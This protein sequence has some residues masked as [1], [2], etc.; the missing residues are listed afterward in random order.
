M[1]PLHSR[2]GATAV[3]F[4]LTMPILIAVLGGLLEYSWYL[5]SLAGVV[6]ATREGVRYGATLA[7]KDSPEVEAEAHAAVVLKGLGVDCSGAATCAFAG[8]V[9]STG[10]LD[11]LT[12]QTTVTYVPIAGLV[13]APETLFASVT[14][15]LEQQPED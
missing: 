9:A 8:T 5:Q 10:T 1:R 2:R 14:M 15:A 11:A 7:A 6:H 13:P 12:L 3:E 4:A